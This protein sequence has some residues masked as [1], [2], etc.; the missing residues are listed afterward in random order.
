LD[1]VTALRLQ[2]LD[3]GWVPVPSSPLNKSCTIIGWSTLAVTEFHIENWG[4]TCPSQSNTS[5]VCGRNYFTI[6]LDIVSDPELARRM[7]AL[8]FQHLGFTPFIRIG[9]A[10]KLLLVYRCASGGIRSES[11]LAASGTGDRIDILA[12]GRNFVAYGIHPETHKPY[13]WVGPANPLED[14]PAEAPIVN[15][16]QVEALLDAADKIMP[17]AR[18]ARD[19]GGRPKA[20]DPHRVV[21]PDG[22]VTDGRESLLRDAIWRAAHDIAATG[23]PLTAELLAEVG[24]D[25]FAAAADLEDGK[26]SRHDALIKA[27][28]L[29]RRINGGTV[30]LKLPTPVTQSYSGSEAQSAESGRR[31]LIEILQ[32]FICGALDWFNRDPQADQRA[33]DQLL[34]GPH[35]PVWAT[36]VS[37]GVGKTRLCAETI[38]G[39]RIAR[40]TA[41]EIG[42]LVARSW[43][44]LVPTHRLGD[45]IAKQFIGH[46]ITARVF[47]GRE[48]FDPGDPEPNPEKKRRMVPQPQAGT[49]CARGRRICFHDMLQVRAQRRP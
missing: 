8:A 39:D 15:Q 38:A 5:L 35:A 33:V 19:G 46:G 43:L 34:G 14:T 40:R 21:D 16:A 44:Y 4:R 11:Y 48:A 41:G 1:S 49:V 45:D 13:K 27:R 28:T 24:W 30:K 18:A 42:P 26:W 37:T 31:A 22:K 20:S 12:T 9:R 17:F 47:R 10:P 7:M 36:Q 29:V 2:L 3:G 23:R 32:A 25:L 6:D